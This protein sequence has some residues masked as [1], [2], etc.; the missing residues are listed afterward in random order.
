M[1]ILYIPFSR[2][3]AGDLTLQTEL[4]QKNHRLSSERT[5]AIIYHNDEIDTDI[6]PF[7]VEVY[8]CA[9]GFSNSD[10]MVVSSKEEQVDLVTVA[11]RFNQD[12]FSV[13]NKF[14]AIHLYCCGTKNKNKQ[15]ATILSDNLLRPEYPIYYYSGTLFAPD[16]K[17]VKRSMDASQVQ[18][19]VEQTQQ[20]IYKPVIDTV[21]CTDRPFLKDYSV[22]IWLEEA[23][24]NRRDAFF[25]G[26][27]TRRE[28][29]INSLRSPSTK[30]PEEPDNQEKQSAFS[31]P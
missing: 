16:N 21:E 22:S 20:F 6:L 11:T 31:F 27:R 10:L 13:F 18:I 7:R 9:H 17:G 29:K 26:V 2:D 23:V 1:I 3:K 19:P 25:A 30:K 8:I 24:Q 28:E 15:L 5:I 12:L 4:W 14:S